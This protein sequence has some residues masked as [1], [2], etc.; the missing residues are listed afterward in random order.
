[1]AKEKGPDKKNVEA[2]DSLL[3][4][5]LAKVQKTEKT[6]EQLSNRGRDL[7]GAMQSMSA[8]LGKSGDALQRMGKLSETFLKSADKTQEAHKGIKNQIQERFNLEISLAA[9]DEQR[10]Q[11]AIKYGAEK[12]NE[13]NAADSLKSIAESQVKAQ[14]DIVKLQ[15]AKNTG[16]R[17]EALSAASTYQLMVQQGSVTKEQYNDLVNNLKEQ[18]D[19]TQELEDQIE[20]EESIAAELLDIRDNTDSWGKSL[21]RAAATAKE[22]AK[23]PAVFGALVLNKVAKTAK[24]AYKGFEDLRESGM[25]AGQALE[26]S[27]KSFSLNSMIGLSDTKGAVQGL[28]EEFG[29]INNV[30][31]E[32]IDNIG[33]VAHEMGISGTEA[34]KLTAQLSQMSGES[35]EVATETLK[36]TNELAKANGIAP[37]KLTKEMAANTKDMHKFTKGGSK[38][39]AKIA[40]E[41]QK[42][43]ISM[44][45]AANAA[46]GLLDFESSIEAQMEASVLLGKEINLDKA[47]QLALEGNSLA[48]AKEVVK[49]LGGQAEFNSMN[50]LE[51]QKAAE[52]AGMTVAEIQKA[53]DAEQNKGKYADENASQA[54]EAAGHALELTAKI[55]SVLKNNGV[56]ILAGIEFL[57]SENAVKA[58]GYARSAAHWIAEKAHIAWKKANEFIGG[59]AAEGAGAAVDVASDAAGGAVDMASDAAE[60]ALEEGA[61][62]G[63]SGSDSEGGFTSLAEGLK[64]MGESG[65]FAGILN[66]AAAGPA[67]IL[68][69]PSIPFLLFMGKISL[70]KLESNFTGL[71]S[72]LNSMA[73]TFVGSAALAVFGLAA[74][75]SILSIPFLLFMGLVPLAQLAPNFM[76]LSAGLTAMAPSFIGSLALGVF[77]IAATLAIASIPFLVAISFLGIPAAAGLSA[78]GVGLTALGTAAATGLPFIAI[79]LIGALGFAMIPFAIALNIATPAIEAFGGVIVGVMGAIPPIIQAIAD[80]FVT[81]LEALS[82]EAILGLFLLGPA[83][84]LAAI[85]MLA[86]AGSLIVLAIAA[87]FGAPALVALGLG[88]MIL[89]TGVMLAAGGLEVIAAI[90]PSIDQAFVGVAT[91]ISSI[92]ALLPAMLM[93]GVALFGMAAGLAAF[94]TAGL[95]TLPTI[96]GL[97]GLSLVAPILIALG[98]SINFDLGGGS[99][100]ES[101]REDSKMDL[102]IEEVRALK[103]AFKTPGVINM[104]GQKV[105]DVIGLAV[106]TS[107]VS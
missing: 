22:I 106:S 74:V 51:Q 62:L 72:G 31:A 91:S 78:L 61:E 98:N 94:A 46:S 89:G 36:F 30:S 55:G 64:A 96:M 13:Q 59:G 9:T 68:A 92:V 14:Q 10:L 75:P 56:L 86:F 45:T 100:V 95:F 32:T 82:P 43:G 27:M 85:G 90:M 25:S 84:G 105:G 48:A 11:A 67:F 16:L 40:V 15:V 69:L 6:F 99:N 28:T 17:G 21:K 26:G 97:I 60:G 5:I 20:M 38:E 70:N 2:V 54:S 102:L 52:A 7:A 3:T 104:D 37:G 71:A 34:A 87:I 47:R 39:F 83:L 79:A 107:G 4:Q 77:A 53:M 93:M 49:Q 42:I 88:M 58:L 73:S 50:V 33:S 103:A 41:A 35:T 66:V 63:G 81:M 65:V 29:T 23:D 76:S 80:G 1:M 18:Q 12:A 24:E 8:E 44:D 57:V 19:I 101:S